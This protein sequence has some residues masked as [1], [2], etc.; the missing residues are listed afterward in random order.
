MRI[1]RERDKK[2]FLHS[3]SF[4]SSSPSR[5][6]SL[7]CIEEEESLVDWLIAKTI[8]KRAK[9]GQMRGEKGRR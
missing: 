2:A 7:P 9:G 1:K 8:Y 6:Q 3:L 5:T 4:N